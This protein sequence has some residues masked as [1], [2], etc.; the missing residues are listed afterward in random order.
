[1]FHFMK[2]ERCQKCFP[3][4]DGYSC[5]YSVFFLQNAQVE[6]KTNIYIVLRKTIKSISWSTQVLI[7]PSIFVLFSKT[8]SSVTTVVGKTPF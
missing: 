8:G 4:S 6:I 5:N 3:K 7:V 1:M 2:T